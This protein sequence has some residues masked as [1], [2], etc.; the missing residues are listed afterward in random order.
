MLCWVGLGCEC[1]S[2]SYDDV[3]RCLYRLKRE[4]CLVLEIQEDAFFALCSKNENKIFSI[5]LKGGKI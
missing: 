4:F 5:F 3:L 1:L 2:T